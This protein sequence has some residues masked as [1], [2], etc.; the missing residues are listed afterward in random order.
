MVIG[1]AVCPVHASGHLFGT[2]DEN[3][4]GEDTQDDVCHVLVDE[5]MPTRLQRPRTDAEWDEPP[6]PTELA[7]S[8]AGAA[9][10]GALSEFP[11]SRAGAMSKYLALRIVSG[12]GL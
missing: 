5:E 7:A 4:V 11:P 12:K 6:A 2:G 3:E 9:V 1:V 10:A 8:A